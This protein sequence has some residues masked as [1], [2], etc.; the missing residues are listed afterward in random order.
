MVPFSLSRDLSDV[1]F[2]AGERDRKTVH[3]IVVHVNLEAV[4]TLRT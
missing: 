1:L 2:Y 3:P 4:M